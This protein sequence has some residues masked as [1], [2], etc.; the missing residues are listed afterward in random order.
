MRVLPNL[1]WRMV[2]MPSQRSTSGCSSLS[3]SLIR[4]PATAN[5]PNRQWYVQGRRPWLG[6]SFRA[7]D[8]S[9]GIKW[10]HFR[11][12][13]WGP[14]PPTFDFRHTLP[15]PLRHGRKASNEFC[16]PVCWLQAAILQH[17]NVS[18]N[19]EA[20]R[21]GNLRRRSCSSALAQLMALIVVPAL[22]A[23]YADRI[24]VSPVNR[25][26]SNRCCQ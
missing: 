18:I 5:S 26:S 16:V 25:S 24:S 3:A 9:A 15:Y 20:F 12:S 7:A 1:V 6:D 14:L 17:L 10:S 21:D 4:K 22:S 2:R 13:S 23:R 19:T 8:V 11:R